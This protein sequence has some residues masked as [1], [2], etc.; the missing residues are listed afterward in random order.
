MGVVA[1]DSGQPEIRSSRLD[2]AYSNFNSAQRGYGLW[3]QGNT[4]VTVLRCTFMNNGTS[5]DLIPGD[6]GGRGIGIGGGSSATIVQSLISSNNDSGMLVTESASVTM[7]RS[8]LR[9]NKYGNGALILDNATV[10]F[11]ANRFDRNG[12]VRDPLDLSAG[13]NGIEF[14]MNYHGTSRVVG[15][16]FTENTGFGIFLASGNTTISGNT[17]D[18]N[19][20][21]IGVE[22]ID[23]QSLVTTIQ[24]NTFRVPITA[25]YE[26]GLLIYGPGAKV[27]LGGSVAGQK[28]TFVNFPK[29]QSIHVSPYTPAKVFQGYPDMDLALEDNIFI[30]SPD[31]IRYE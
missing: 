20:C 1:N 26:H 11:E 24:G 14:Y 27:V 2:L 30:N 12:L 16:T 25:T 9:Y 8:T 18:N 15:N 7:R 17:F 29:Q 23:G 6:G 3:L 10:D 28:N 13:R 4:Q 5:K 21:G 31:P 19:W 22:G